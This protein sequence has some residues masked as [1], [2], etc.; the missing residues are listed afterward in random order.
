LK[1][2]LSEKHRSRLPSVISPAEMLQQLGDTLAVIAANAQII[3]EQLPALDRMVK[4]GKTEEARASAAA[5]EA[6]AQQW[7]NSIAGGTEGYWL[8]E[9]IQQTLAG[10]TTR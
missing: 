7:F 2:N 8:K 6:K 10:S 1:I 5:L 4:E 9:K 3:A